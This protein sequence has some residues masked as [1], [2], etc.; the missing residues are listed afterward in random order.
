MTTTRLGVLLNP[1]AGMGGRVGLHGTDG[2]ALADAV[3][4]GAVPVAPQRMRRAL[5]RLGA[6][7]P[8]P[9]VVTVSGVMGAQVLP[10]GWIAETIWEPAEPS[11][12]ADT[13]AAARRLADARVDLLLFGGGDGTA[14]DLVEVLGDRVPVLGVPCGVKMHS[15]VFAIS[16][17]AAGEMAARYLRRP[18]PV[19][20]VDVLDLAP[21]GVGAMAVATV[22]VAGD[23]LQRSKSG[24]AA[25]SDLAALG[26]SVVDRMEPGRIYLL[27]PGTT[28]AQ[29]SE[30]LAVPASLL[31]V[32]AVL[33]GRLVAAD[34][35]ESELRALL[36]DHPRATLV[37]G[38]V[39]GQGFLLGR[40]N[41]QLSPAVLAAVGP[42]N[43]EII[44]SAEKVAT[45]DPPVLRIDLDDRELGSRLCGFH[46]VR[47]S[48]RRSTVMRVVA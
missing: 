18:G 33:D 28:V 15:G 9:E 42:E 27:G 45:L 3:R 20:R 46:R 21:D 11:T 29:V 17:E 24:A 8:D 40:G 14:R 1:I 47:T 25:G 12:A 37:L 34:A 13:R 32:D 39:G 41:Q 16:P 7:L 30:A 19:C 10:A 5:A 23:G 26:R 2:D 6:A 44:A 31:G 35:S 48:P 36:V 43:I 4:A 22:P 38:V